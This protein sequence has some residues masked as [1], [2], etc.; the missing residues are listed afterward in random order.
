[1]NRYCTDRFKIQPIDNF[2]KGQGECELLIGL[3]ADEEPGKDRTGNFMKCKNVTYRYPLY[4]DG[5][6][7]NDCKVVLR[8]YG[9]EPNFPVYMARGGCKYCPFKTV[10]E[11]K[12]MYFLDRETFEEGR[13]LENRVQD[14][15]KRH[16]AISMSGKSF[17]QLA[18]ECEAEISMW[19]ENEI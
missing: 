19:G 16:F 18:A 8:K 12:A 6:S 10:S 13:R 15:R 2:L 4:E 5:L 9:L 11:Y 7:R 1:R 3:N 17:N 14:K